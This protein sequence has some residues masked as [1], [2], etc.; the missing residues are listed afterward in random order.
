MEFRCRKRWRGERLGDRSGQGGRGWVTE[1]D[2]VGRGWVTE[3]DKVGRGWVTEEGKIGR[4]WV[5]EEGKV[6][7]GRQD[8]PRGLPWGHKAWH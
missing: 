5:I 3:E 1:V 4:G 2:K 6:G 7:R 8:G